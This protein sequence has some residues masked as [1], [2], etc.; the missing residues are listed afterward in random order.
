MQIEAMR[1]M[2]LGALAGGLIVYVSIEALEIIIRRTLE[3]RH[4]GE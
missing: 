2:A 3:R 1:L 4:H